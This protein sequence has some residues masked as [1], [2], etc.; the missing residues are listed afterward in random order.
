[1][2]CSMYSAKLFQCSMYSAA[3]MTLASQY[4]SKWYGVHP[5]KTYL[6]SFPPPTDVFVITCNNC[7]RP[8]LL[9]DNRCAGQLFGD[10]A[11]DLCCRCSCRT[12]SHLQ[13]AKAR[14]KD[15]Y[16]LRGR[17]VGVFH[18]ST[19]MPVLCMIVHIY[20]NLSSRLVL[21]A[22]VANAYVFKE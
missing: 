14:D 13:W 16:Y 7:P 8:S 21:W 17:W 20:V 19:R 5:S 15:F 11:F 10:S 2:S 18:W 6:H 4:L 22:M 3:L 1:M 9:I 12:K